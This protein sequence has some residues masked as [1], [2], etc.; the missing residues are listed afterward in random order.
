MFRDISPQM[1]GLVSNWCTTL[2]Y[3]ITIVVYFACVHTL[4]K[5]RDD[6]LRSTTWILFCT[7]TIQFVLSTIYVA[8]ALRILIEGFIW[9]VNT[10]GGTLEYWIDPSVRSQVVSKAVYVTNSIVGDSIMVWRVYAVWGQNLYIC[11][12]PIFLVFGT[13]LTGYISIK[14][15]AGISVNSLDSLFIIGKWILATWALSISTQVICT[16]LIAGKIWWH[17]RHSAGSKA[18]YLSAIAIVV[19]SGALYTIATIFL[20]AFFDMKTQAGAIIGDMTAQIA[21]S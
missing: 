6:R 19:E 8:L 18:R 2:L 12:I 10:P 5:R 15:L 21:V 9:A 17:A 16:S 4:I 13:I 7:A 14:Q 20:L 11:I 1:A 3:G